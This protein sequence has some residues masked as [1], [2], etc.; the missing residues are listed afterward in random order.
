MVGLFLFPQTEHYKGTLSNY[1]SNVVLY[2]VGIAEV[3]C[4]ITKATRRKA[5]KY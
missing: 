1:L 5:V 3:H 2:I 4:Q